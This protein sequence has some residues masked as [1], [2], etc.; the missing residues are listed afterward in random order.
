MKPF[1]SI[2]IPVFNQMGKMDSCVASL[3]NQTFK[4]FE[5]VLVDDASTDA[6]PAF[7]QA[8]AEQD[9]R[10]HVFR[11]EVNSSV[12]AARYTGMEKSEGEYIL[13]ADSDDWLEETACEV[14]H[15]RLI[16]APA[17]LLVYGYVLEPEGK[18]M[19]PLLP[20]DPLKAC[21][22]GT[23]IQ[24]VWRNCYS[25]A[26]IQKVLARV[27]PFY[28][29][30]GED[31]LLAAMYFACADTV[32]TLDA[33]LYHYVIG[34]GM[35]TVRKGLSEEKMKKDLASAKASGTHLTAFIREYAPDYLPLAEKDA[36]R[37]VKFV[38]FQNIYFEEDWEKVFRVMGFF[39]CEEYRNVFEFGCNVLFPNKIR[40]S[41]GIDVGRFSFD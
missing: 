19:S 36:E 33:Y 29:N 12:M 20:E 4:D 23:L 35:S 16:K 5:V 7:L 8:L 18:K 40:R 41:V 9:S 25:A 17:D 27:E 38:L 21:L 24:N 3:K 30:M 13:F 14:L 22:D 2:I 39:N 28:C 37:M 10:F 15:E 34:C 31:N 26:L 1:F 6:S 32:S 11:H